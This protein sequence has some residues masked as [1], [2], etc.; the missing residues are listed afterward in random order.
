MYMAHHAAGAKCLGSARFLP[1]ECAVAAMPRREGSMNAGEPEFGS[2][3]VREI[4]C[5]IAVVSESGP[6]RCKQNLRI[7]IC[8][9]R[10]GLAR[11]AQSEYKYE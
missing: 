3:C 8:I 1:S 11:A 7:Y 10:A 2:M 6:R 4:V 5:E 9:H